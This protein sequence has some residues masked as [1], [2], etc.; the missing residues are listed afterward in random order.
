MKSEFGKLL[1]QRKNNG[2]YETVLEEKVPEKIS[3]SATRWP[4]FSVF[5]FA[6]SGTIKLETEYYIIKVVVSPIGRIRVTEILKK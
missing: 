5:G 1:L 3:I 2:S 6:A 4:S